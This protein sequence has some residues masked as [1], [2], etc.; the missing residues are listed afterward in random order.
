ME[1]VEYQ[2]MAALEDDMWWFRA[3]HSRLV[4]RVTELSL[5]SEARI[6]DAGCGTGGLLRR[7]GEA[8]P[9]IERIGLEY[10][11]EAASIAA[12]KAAAAVFAGTVNAM[13]F[14]ASHFDAILSADVLCH[15]QVEPI[16]ALAEFHRCLKPGGTL[17]M[18]LPAY[19]WMQSAHDKSVHNARRYTAAGARRLV[20]RARFL[21]EA[22]GYWNSFLFPLMLLHRF[23]T[24][25][26]RVGSDMRVFSPWL[27]SLFHAITTA[28]RRMGQMGLQLP[29]GGSVL[30]SAVKPTQ[31]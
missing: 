10:N 8:I 24:G 1:C 12:T 28:E 11:S 21:V 20:E 18:S 5:P 26:L 7:I 14:R 25:R 31:S 4:D 15:K 13:P 9:W 6:L 29:F 2:K 22:S 17:L 23:T 27:D 30:L 3:L 16:S 19:D